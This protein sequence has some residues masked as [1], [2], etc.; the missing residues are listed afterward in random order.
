MK[1]LHLHTLACRTRHR[2]CTNTLDHCGTAIAAHPNGVV[3]TAACLTLPYIQTDTNRHSAL[4]HWFR[5]LLLMSRWLQI[6]MHHWAHNTQRLSSCRAIC[7]A[8]ARVTKCT[9]KVPFT[10]A[11]RQ[12]GPLTPPPPQR[13]LHSPAAE[14]QLTWQHR[15]CCWSI[16]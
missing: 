4:P 7:S 14:P 11:Q 15:S 8:D 16:P 6:D 10:C 3:L 1:V 9:H 2:V 5:D 12:A 13:I